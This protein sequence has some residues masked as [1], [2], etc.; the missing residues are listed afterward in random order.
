MSVFR[1]IL[2]SNSNPLT[3]IPILTEENA[4]RNMCICSKLMHIRNENFKSSLRT[5]EFYQKRSLE[6]ILNF[7][8]IFFPEVSQK[9]TPDTST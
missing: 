3:D 4:S 5:C 7:F 8:Q 9:N 1:F 6:L 2:L